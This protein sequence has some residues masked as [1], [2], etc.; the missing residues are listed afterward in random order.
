MIVSDGEKPVEGA[1]IQLCTA[2]TCSLGKTDAEGVAVFQQP[3]GEYEIHVLKAPEGY[4]AD[5]TVYKTL[6]TYSD[7]NI[8]LKPAK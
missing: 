6:P 5:E 4:A 8:T 2:D 3:E 7:V 1:M